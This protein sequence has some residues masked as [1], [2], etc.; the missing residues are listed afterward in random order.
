VQQADS[1]EGGAYVGVVGYEGADVEAGEA[2]V[3][4]RPYST[5]KRVVGSA[6][7]VVGGRDGERASEMGMERRD[8]NG[9]GA[10]EAEVGCVECR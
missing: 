1:V 6:A 8:V 10:E 4:A 7:A 5:W 9:V 2:E 3:F